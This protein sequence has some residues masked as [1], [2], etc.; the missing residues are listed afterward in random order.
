MFPT[1]RENEGLV[2]TYPIALTEPPYHAFVGSY[3]A[4]GMME[5]RNLA[6]RLTRGSYETLMYQAELTLV[7]LEK[8]PARYWSWCEA[9]LRAW[10]E[11]QSRCYIQTQLELLRDAAQTLIQGAQLG[12][13]QAQVA[14]AAPPPPP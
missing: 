4:G 11:W 9:G 8:V 14:Q 6:S 10:G 5:R 2:G 1:V 7:V 3:N 12:Q 13:A